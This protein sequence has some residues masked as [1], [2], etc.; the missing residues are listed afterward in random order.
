M[1]IN[2]PINN[3]EKLDPKFLNISTIDNVLNNTITSNYEF[4]PDFFGRFNIWI[5]KGVSTLDKPYP[6]LTTNLET[7][8]KA[9]AD[10]I[11]QYPILAEY[12]TFKNSSFLQKFDLTGRINLE[13]YKHEILQARNIIKNLTLIH[14]ASKE[15]IKKSHIITRIF[16]FFVNLFSVNFNHYLNKTEF[17][18]TEHETIIEEKEKLLKPFETYHTVSK[19][20]NGITGLFTAANII[21]QIFN[22]SYPNVMPA[23]VTYPLNIA[24][25]ITVAR[26]A[27]SHLASLS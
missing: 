8:S 11:R 9:L 23:V 21:V 20:F 13:K 10:Q 2:I 26:N 4:K 16:F 5:K 24:T 7:L 15:I 1:A 19:Y 12:T 25:A 17:Y 14:E 27:Y 6:Y 18:L 22:Y 3:L